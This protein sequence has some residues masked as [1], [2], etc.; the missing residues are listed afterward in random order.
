V[1]TTPRGVSWL[2][3][4]YGANTFGAVL[5][6]LLTGF[7]LLRIHD[8]HTAACVAGAL[9]GIMALCAF[10][11]SGP[12]RAFVAG[13][14]RLSVARTGWVWNFRR[15]AKCKCDPVSAS[16]P[17]D[18]LSGDIVSGAGAGLVYFTI[19]LSGLCALGAEV[20]WTRLLSLMLGPTVYTFSIILAVFLS[21]LGIGSGIGSFLAQR[22]LHPERALGTC[23]LLLSAGIAWAA[24]L[25]AKSLPY[26]PIDPSL[27]RSPWFEFQLDAVRCVCAILPAACLWGASFPLALAAA[28]PG[29]ADPARLVGRIYAANTIGAVLGALGCSIFLSACLKKAGD[30]PLTLSY[31]C[32]QFCTSFGCVTQST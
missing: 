7:Y 11:L 18:R 10:L 12:G 22:S 25:V 17:A 4:F 24:L 26:W 21:G 13:G 8:M 31:F 19:A 1:D 32:E 30:F 29:C 6:C 14:E 28:A 9:N 2:G 23:Q 20:V 15:C 27:S 5:G 16:I 3:L